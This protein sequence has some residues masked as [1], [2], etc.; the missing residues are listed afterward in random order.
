[1]RLTDISLVENRWFKVIEGDFADKRAHTS[2]VVGNR[3]YTYGGRGKKVDGLIEYDFI[4]NEFRELTFEGVKPMHRYFH[5]ACV[6]D[7]NIYILMGI[8]D[9]NLNGIF[10]IYIDSPRKELI[11]P[12]LNNSYK[13]LLNSQV[14]SDIIIKVGGGSIYAHKAILYANSKYFEAMFGGKMK[15]SYEKEITIDNVSYDTFRSIMEY[16]YTGFTDVSLHNAVELLRASDTFLLKELGE[17]CEG[18]L[19]KALVSAEV[20]VVIEILLLAYTYSCQELLD[21][22]CTLLLKKEKNQRDIAL[23]LLDESTQEVVQECLAKKIGRQ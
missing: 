11:N 18:I 7:N 20:E 17:Q 6:Y 15:E 21:S 3:M 10:C 4:K 13:K 2:V 14:L 12:T 16:L 22:S 19:S 8:C 1:M 9:R 5:N 23:D